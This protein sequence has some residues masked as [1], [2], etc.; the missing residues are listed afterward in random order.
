MIPI[1]QMDDTHGT[2]EQLSDTLSFPFHSRTQ[3]L[4]DGSIIK[5]I[6]NTKPEVWAL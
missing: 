5:D 2:A 4:I 6:C 3:I 1:K